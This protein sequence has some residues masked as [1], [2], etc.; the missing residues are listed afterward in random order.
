M[1]AGARE[2]FIKTFFIS[3]IDFACLELTCNV[4]FF[5][6]VVYTP[7]EIHLQHF[8]SSW[9]LEQSYYIYLFSSFVQKGHYHTPCP[10]RTCL[11]HLGLA[12]P[13]HRIQYGTVSSDSTFM[14]LL[15]Q[16]EQRIEQQVAINPFRI[17]NFKQML[18]KYEFLCFFRHKICSNVK[19]MSTL[20]IF[21]SWQIFYNTIYFLS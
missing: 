1:L 14:L 6:M 20:L 9:R 2:G 10:D 19:C 4:G 15:P 11:K 21:R 8:I 5:P 7:T 17:S 13:R 12:A 18:L 16:W 3:E